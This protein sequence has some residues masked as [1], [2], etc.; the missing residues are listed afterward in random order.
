M[1]M[2]FGPD[3]SGNRPDYEE[4][5]REQEAEARAEHDREER[6]AEEHETK[7]REA[8]HEPPPKA[9]WWRRMFGA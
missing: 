4:R 9:S 3:R 7:E 8:K 5:A 2:P 1:G 6:E